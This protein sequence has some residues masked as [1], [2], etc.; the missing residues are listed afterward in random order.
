MCYNEKTV[1]WKL[2]AK[3]LVE[4]GNMLFTKGTASGQYILI[5]GNIVNYG[6]YTGAFKNISQAILEPKNPIELETPANAVKISF[7]M[8]D[9]EMIEF[10]ISKIK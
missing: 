4:T 9:T 2:D 1:E 6:D 7:K 5:E 10:D 3:H 8:M